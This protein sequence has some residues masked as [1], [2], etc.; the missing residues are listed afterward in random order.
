M[1]NLHH[2]KRYSG[3]GYAISASFEDDKMILEGTQ[4]EVFL[5]SN[6]EFE[7]GG[8]NNSLIFFKYPGD[9]E[10]LGYLRSSRR[11]VSELKQKAP[12]N[13]LGKQVF[14][15]RVGS[16]LSVGLIIGFFILIPLG[17]YFSKDYLVEVVVDQVPAKYEKQLGESILPILLPESKK[18][19]YEP[20]HRSLDKLIVPLTSQLNTEEHSI[21]FYISNSPEVNAFALPGG[22]MVFNLGLLEKAESGL[23]IM[24]VTAHEL[25]HI[26][27]R[28]SLKSI[29]SS[30]GIFTL[31][32][33]ILGDFS[34]LLVIGDE[35]V[36]LMQLGYSRSLELEADRIGFNLMVEAGYSP[37]GMIHFFKKIM[38]IQEDS[39]M[40]TFEDKLSVLSTHPATNLRIQLIQERLDEMSDKQKINL[41][42]KSNGY[43]SLR[44]IVRSNKWK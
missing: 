22:I 43:K 37:I 36:R 16:L 28:H 35:L 29:V 18:V 4:K 25:A 31:L 2:G 5:L 30:L 23:E 33:V 24:G 19:T 32:S 17:L 44:K 39:N 27:N 1:N 7:L 8:S 20:L 14:K 42:K 21:D 15:S 10:A 38:E 34:A 40:P 13:S 41:K 6:L 26:Q 11:L 9:K 12:G 3:E